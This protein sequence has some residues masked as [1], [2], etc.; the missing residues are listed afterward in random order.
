MTDICMIKFPRI[1][2]DYRYIE[3]IGSGSQAQVDLYKSRP[4]SNTNNQD[5]SNLLSNIASL[6]L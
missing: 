2:I 4:P 6:G 3:R 5:N 1:D